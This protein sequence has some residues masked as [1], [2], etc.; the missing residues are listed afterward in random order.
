MKITAQRNP[1]KVEQEARKFLTDTDWYVVRFVEKQVP[2]PAD[3]GQRRDE[4]RAALSKED[5]KS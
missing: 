3:I 2:V 1:A 5:A 4:A